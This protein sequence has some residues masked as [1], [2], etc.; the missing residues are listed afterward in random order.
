VSINASVPDVKSVVV[1]KFVSTAVVKHI[2]LI[3][4]VMQFVSI[5]VLFIGVVIAKAG[6]IVNTINEGQCVLNVVV[7]TIVS[8]GV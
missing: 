5:T 7:L 4:A 6:L 2:V 3:V 8:T 1:H